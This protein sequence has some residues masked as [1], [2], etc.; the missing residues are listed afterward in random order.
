MNPGDIVKVEVWNNP[1]A[2]EEYFGLITEVHR[3]SRSATRKYTVL[4]SLGKWIHDETEIRQVI[5]YGGE[6]EC[7]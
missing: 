6:D 7:R 5:Y 1:K 2:C 4:S 3:G